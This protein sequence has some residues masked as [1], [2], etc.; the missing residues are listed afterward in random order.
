MKP[1]KTVLLLLV[2]MFVSGISAWLLRGEYDRQF[3]LAGHF[4]IVSNASQDHQVTLVFP[5][6]QQ[7]SFKLKQ[8]SSFD[9]QL[10]DTGEGAI[11]VTIDGKARDQVGYVTT[12]NSPVILVIGDR[13]TVFSQI[14]PSQVAKDK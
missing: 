1:A 8:G 10:S 13:Q 9:F 12:L 14:F 5:S 7:K 6:K 2:A 11:A 3:M 4:H